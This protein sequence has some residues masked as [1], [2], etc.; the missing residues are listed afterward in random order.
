M[1]NK[2][3]QVLYKCNYK[4]IKKYKL[5]SL[6][7]KKR[8]EDKSPNKIENTYSK[9]HIIIIGDWCIEKQIANF[10]STPNIR[11]KRK[12]SERFKIF[13]IDEFRISCLNYPLTDQ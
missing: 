7:N 9:E 3:N 8:A 11:I 1:W 2:D 12:L 13:N 4:K 10:I 6:I 5:Y